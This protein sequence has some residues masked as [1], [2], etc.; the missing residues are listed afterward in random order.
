VP[1]PQPWPESP[2]AG[3]SLRS[4][5]P[6][7]N[8]ASPGPAQRAVRRLARGDVPPC[9]ARCAAGISPTH[10]EAHVAPGALRRDGAAGQIAMSMKRERCSCA[11]TVTVS[12][13]PLRCLA[14]MKSASPARGDSLS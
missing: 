14:T 7:R 6:G 1:L 10:G 12:V 5:P 11:A 13:G 3:R 9:H 8:R 2:A 4:Q